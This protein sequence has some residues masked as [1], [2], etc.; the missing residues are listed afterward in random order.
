MH[1]RIKVFV[2]LDSLHGRERL[3]SVA[4]Q[5]NWSG[6]NGA[7][8]HLK[9]ITSADLSDRLSC[10]VCA[11]SH[12]A[13]QI[14]RARIALQTCAKLLRSGSSPLREVRIGEVN[15]RSVSATACYA[16]GCARRQL[17]ASGGGHVLGTYAAMLPSVCR[18][19]MTYNRVARE[20][21]R[22]LSTPRRPLSL[23]IR[24]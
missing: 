12:G 4:A 5:R 19:S 11:N 21:S 18:R 14:R 15:V 1:N 20:A 22:A 7:L 16:V 3:S 6:R 2:D 10:V 9:E 13:T 17:I 23:W 24:V 8:R